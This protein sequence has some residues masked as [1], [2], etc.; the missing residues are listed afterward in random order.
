M[1]TFLARLWLVLWR[2]KV[3]PPQE[4]VPASCVMIAAP[5]TS[6]WDFPLTLAMARVS[7]VRIRWLG[8]DALFRGLMGPVM[9]RLGGVSIDRS[10]PQGMVAALADEFSR[11]DDL[12][13]VV[14]AEGTRSKTDYWK[15]GFYRIA[16]A[17]G[18]PIVCAF[19]DRSTRSGG[20][21]PVFRP[22]GDVRADM[23]IVRAFYQGKVGLKAGG[24]SAPRLKEE[25]ALP[26]DE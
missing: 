17:A 16:E 15:S 14:P 21:G 7:G 3:V 2:W 10:A 24:T 12:V 13:L 9:R 20:F 26:T 5:H 8:K 4:P 1:L 18:V 11:H 6:N 22:S 23:D 25:D 19:V